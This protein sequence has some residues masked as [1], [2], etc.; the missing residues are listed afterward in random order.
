MI[1]LPQPLKD[2]GINDVSCHTWLIMDRWGL[3]SPSLIHGGTQAASVWTSSMQLLTHSDQKRPVDPL[4][5]E[6]QMIV[7][8]L[9]WLL[10]GRETAGAELRAPRSK[11]TQAP[12]WR[13]QGVSS[14]I[15][16]G[17]TGIALPRPGEAGSESLFSQTRSRANRHL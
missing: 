15:C 10:G 5:L 16:V 11:L 14:N 3:I 8:C 6:L 4:E 12:A 1:L 17:N 2:A 9:M 7:S 13:L